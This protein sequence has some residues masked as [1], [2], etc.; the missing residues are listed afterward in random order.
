M[1]IYLLKRYQR[2][3]INFLSDLQS[4]GNYACEAKTRKCRAKTLK[5]F[6]LLPNSFPLS[7]ALSNQMRNFPSRPT[8]ICSK[9]SRDAWRISQFF[10]DK[11]LLIHNFMKVKLR[12][13]ALKSILTWNRARWTC[14]LNFYQASYTE[15]KITAKPLSGWSSNLTE[16]GML[17]SRWVA[18]VISKLFIYDLKVRAE[19]I[20]LM[21]D[22]TRES[23]V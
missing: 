20:K 12:K 18:A 9:T 22:T 13:I 23:F 7:L 11:N 17:Q 16:H 3:I 5:P 4:R 10:R 8:T 19:A 14:N 1:N 15:N 21:T 6:K 2:P